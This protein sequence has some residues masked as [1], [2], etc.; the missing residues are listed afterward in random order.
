MA[1]FKPIPNPYIVGNPIKSREMFFGREDDF[2][3]IKRKLEGGAKNY[4]I[5]LCGE[6]RSGKTS[7][8]FQ[9]LMG[10]L[11]ARFLPILVDMQTMAGVQNE[12]E[13]FQRVARDVVKA[14]QLEE[15]KLSD[16]DFLSSQA[17][18]YQVMEHMLDDI[19]RLQPEKSILFLVDEY[20]LV[21]SKIEEGALSVNFVHFLSGILES[22]RRVSF[23]FTG[24]QKI[25]QRQNR[26]WNVLLGKSIYRNVSFLRKPDTLRLITE[27]VQEYIRYDPAVV[28]RI[29]RL[30]SGQPFYT[31]V[32]CQNLIDYLNVHQ[33]GNV[34]PEIL[35]AIVQEILENPLPQMIYFW[36]NLT[37]N[38]KLVLSLMAE[39]LTHPDEWI[40]P[41]D[42]R[43]VS[44]RKEY[45]IHASIQAINTTL[46]NLFH[47][48]IVAKTDDRYSFQV[49]LF[50]LWIKRDHSIWRVMKHVGQNLS[51]DIRASVEVTAGAPAA[52]PEATRRPVSKWTWAALG[53]ILAAIGAY[54][55]VPILKEA[56]PEPSLAV[57]PP[58]QQ[59]VGQSPE[60]N[61]QTPPPPDFGKQKA[62][63]PSAQTSQP[64][65][66]ARQSSENPIEAQ[67][68]ELASAQSNLNRRKSAAD[69]ARATGLADYSEAQRL[70]RRAAQ[71]QDGGDLAGAITDLRS[72]AEQYRQAQKTAEGREDQKVEALSARD[73]MLRARS[74]WS[75][76][77]GSGASAGPAQGMEQEA[78]HLFDQK[79]YERAA[80]VFNTAERLYNDALSQI[81]TTSTAESTQAQSL[82]MQLLETKAALSDDDRIME[83]ANR[84]ARLEEEAIA[85]L[86]SGRY[87]SAADSYQQAISLY[88][89]A[90]QKR[91]QYR[92]QVDQFVEDYQ[93]A[94]ES[95]DNRRLGELYVDFPKSDQDRWRTFFQAAND[96]KVNIKT[97]K[98]VYRPAGVLLTLS[99]QMQFAGAAGGGQ[100]N[101]WEVE[102]RDAGKRLKIEA[103]HENR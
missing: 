98:V 9:I 34:T 56:A 32:V 27:P 51:E 48:E 97:G 92:A 99:V 13:F 53:V 88:N 102:L 49:D 12:G 16:Y 87:Q 90:Q 11:G 41:E 86:N 35:D 42:I 82:K 23:V 50:R 24:S 20:E 77:A 18:P 103:I 71:K 40:S 100:W 58:A 25:E 85:A 15:L 43:K 65:A 22:E 19:R 10:Q 47:S 101:E 80:V 68:R 52:R 79:N 2:E 75:R 46:E 95:R 28:E 21:D 62:E 54:V 8:L 91:Q 36:N 7:I 73:Q 29:Y 76:A 1:E 61:L 94:L 26:Y 66:T 37:N 4:I 83:E 67:R 72:A 33:T 30:T 55:V 44:S 60:N 69:R 84:A 38:K 81:K 31:Q 78:Q 6:R 17:S 5:V 3:F 96:L 64:P 63:E 57:T 45:G 74:A 70:E 59:T 39:I 93:R 89:Q 14:L